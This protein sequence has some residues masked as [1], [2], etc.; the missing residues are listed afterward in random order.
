MKRAQGIPGAQPHPLPHVR[1]WKAHECSHYRSSQ[2]PA[3]PAQWFDGL[4]R[5]L[6]GVHDLLVTVACRSSLHCRFSTAQGRQDHTPLPHVL[7][8]VVADTHTSIASRLTIVTTRSPL[9]PRRDGGSLTLIYEKRKRIV[10][11]KERDRFSCVTARRANQ[12]RA[13]IV[14]LTAAQALSVAG[15]A[16][17]RTLLSILESWSV[18]ANLASV[19]LLSYCDCFQGGGA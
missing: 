3:F 2:T 13:G 11:Q 18:L 5:A 10:L 17:V 14:N 6:P 16:L 15:A 19:P 9:L 8:P 4:L 1:T 7:V 12:A